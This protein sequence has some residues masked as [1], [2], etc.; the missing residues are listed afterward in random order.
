VFVTLAYLLGKTADD[1]SHE[2]NIAMPENGS[3]GMPL[4][5]LR[6]LFESI[7]W[8]VRNKRIQVA[9]YNGDFPN[10]PNNEKIERQAS[11]FDPSQR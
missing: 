1:L 3:G 10:S 2:V 8:I 9:F 5:R 7:D 6:P 4:S 11:I